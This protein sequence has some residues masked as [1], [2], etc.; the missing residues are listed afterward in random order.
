[1]IDFEC[2]N[3]GEGLEAP[4]SMAGLPVQCPKCGTSIPGVW[5]QEQ[6]LAFKPRI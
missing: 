2:T 1:M 4:I 3:C 6:A 5:S